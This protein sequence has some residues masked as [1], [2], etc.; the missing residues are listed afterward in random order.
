MQIDSKQSVS[1]T[2]KLSALGIQFISLLE[3]NTL[4]LE[5]YI[6]NAVLENPF[7]ILDPPYSDETVPTPAR[8]QDECCHSF[9]ENDAEERDPFRTI[10]AKPSMDLYDYLSFQLQA[11]CASPHIKQY[12]GLL[13]QYI[14]TRGRFIVTIDTIAHAHNLPLPPLRKALALLQSLEPAGVGANDLSECLAL[15]LQRNKCQ[16]PNAF[17]IVNCFLEELARNDLKSIASKM[18]IPLPQIKRSCAVVRSLNPDPCEDFQDHYNTIYIYPDAY[19]QYADGFWQIHLSNT[20]MERLR[21][22]PDLPYDIPAPDGAVTQWLNERQSNAQLLISDIQRRNA[23]IRSLM[24]YVI[25]YQCGN[26]LNNRSPLQPLTLSDI[27][28]TTGLHISTIGRIVK[29]KVICFPSGCR[30]LASFLSKHIRN[31]S[32]HGVKMALADL[33]SSEDASKPL[34]DQQLSDRLA[35]HGI[36]VSRRTVTKYREELGFSNAAKRKALQKKGNATL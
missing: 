11:V 1:V 32:V 22:C 6:N 34:S 33:V 21:F 26:A 17:V 35:E 18:N 7:L 20:I 28:N 29:G 36:V 8:M 15:Q 14:D 5:N 31:T 12:A 23:T 24:E 27:S 13:L 3:F 16:D 25:N 10:K 2:T 19:A 9:Y 30:P 4:Q